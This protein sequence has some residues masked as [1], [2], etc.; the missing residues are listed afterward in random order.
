MNVLIGLTCM[1]ISG[2]RQLGKR[3]S[4]VDQQTR[5]Q[6]G[7]L[8][9]LHSTKKDDKEPVE[10]DESATWRMSLF[11]S[12]FISFLYSKLVQMLFGQS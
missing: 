10:D 3:R 8:E 11:L 2:R 9:F 7:L 4:S 1:I 12:Y 6:E 5:F